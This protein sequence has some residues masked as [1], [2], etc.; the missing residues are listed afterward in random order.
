MAETHEPASEATVLNFEFAC[1]STHFSAIE[2]LIRALTGGKGYLLVM[3]PLGMPT[4]S[5]GLFLE[6]DNRNRIRLRW[7][8]DSGPGRNL[9]RHE[10]PVGAASNY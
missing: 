6:K 3:L 7:F 2:N 9:L 8:F 1:S 5:A 10:N 4:P